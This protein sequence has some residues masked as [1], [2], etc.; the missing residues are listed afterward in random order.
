MRLKTQMP[1]RVLY[2][3]A[4]KK[5]PV[6]AE[7]L[8]ASSR[9]LLYIRRFCVFYYYRYAVETGIA[10]IERWESFIVNSI[11]LLLAVSLGKQI[12]RMLLFIAAY[13]LRV[14]GN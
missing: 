2:P 11:F 14:L 8:H 10:I 6:Q 4:K 3:M 9:F 1:A 12:L 7:P 5:L 13:I